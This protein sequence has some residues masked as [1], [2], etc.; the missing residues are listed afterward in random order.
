MHLRLKD[1][2]AEYYPF[3]A[4]PHNSR[5]DSYEGGRDVRVQI[6]HYYTWAERAPPQQTPSGEPIPFAPQSSYSIQIS[7]DRAAAQ[8]ARAEI[9]RQV[10]ELR[11][12]LTVNQMPIER[13][14]HQFII[15]ERGGSLHDFLAE[16]GCAVILPPSH[17]DS[18]ML[19]I[20]G[21]ADKLDSGINKVMDL[22]T[23]MQATSVDIARQHANSQAHA[24]ALTRYLRQRQA[25]AELER[26]HDASIVLPTSTDGPTAW[27]IY[28]K[29]AKNGMKA[30]MDI[31]NMISGHP[32]S[33]LSN[34]DVDPFYH[35]HLRQHASQRLRSDIG[36][37]L[38]FPED[39]AES[40]QLVLVYEGPGS[41]SEYQLPRGQPSAADVQAFQN[42]LK[43]AQQQL[44][45]LI[46]T[47]EQIVGRDVEGPQK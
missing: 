15:G 45:S 33:R 8:E 31:M 34:V 47:E 10:A 24:R 11:R 44:L 39:D 36:V 6:P 12:Q 14:R 38:V 17:D 27:E 35:Q 13:G 20:V 37:Q 21:P 18:E 9:E 43:E 42:A 46:N 16:T 2:P 28:S 4:G 30:R 22:A 25:V 32:P 3:L 19:T 1:I 29:D 40:P 41:P 5:V 23:A 7:G 26:I